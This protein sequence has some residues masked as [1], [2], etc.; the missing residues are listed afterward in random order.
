MH[1]KDAEADVSDVIELVL[2][3]RVSAFELQ[4]NKR[5]RG[6]FEDIDKIDLFAVVLD[7]CG[8]REN[9]NSSQQHFET[10]GQRQHFTMKAATQHPEVIHRKQIKRFRKR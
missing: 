9:S 4:Q 2:H 5:T 8:E 3:Q 10:L 1:E 7:I 6:H